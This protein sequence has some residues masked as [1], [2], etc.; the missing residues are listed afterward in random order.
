MRAT[1]AAVG[2]D[3]TAISVITGDRNVVDLVYATDT[4]AARID[5]LQFTIGAGPFLDALHAHTAARASQ[6]MSDL[7]DSTVSSAWPLFAAELRSELNV[8]RVLAYPITADGVLLGVLE[9][10]RR[11][12]DPFTANE[13]HAGHSLA[14]ELGDALR[15]DLS[16]YV[17][18]DLTEPSASD[19]SFRSPRTDVYIAIG[20][21]AARRGTT[22]VDTSAALR[23]YSYAMSQSITALA[24][25]I[26]HRGHDFDANW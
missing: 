6:P 8:R 5:E 13:L 19:R 4:T 12:P 18:D 14:E 2:A 20:M 10:Y 23:A 24:A 9:S 16:A 3:G 21:L 17:M 7:E 11:G 25:D 15:N 22:V 1:S 26:V